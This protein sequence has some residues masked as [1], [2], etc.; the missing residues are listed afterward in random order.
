MLWPEMTQEEWKR[1]TGSLRPRTREWRAAWSALVAQ[2]G[3][4][5]RA[6]ECPLTGE[7]WGYLCSFRD[8]GRWVHEFRHRHHPV[9]QRR[10]YVHV[11]ASEGWSPS[12]D[13]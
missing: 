5:D 10:W 1:W 8:R 12:A 2:T 6:A 3:D 13:R 11:L 4:H 9:K 7:T